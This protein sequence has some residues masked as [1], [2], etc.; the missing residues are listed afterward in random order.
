M[1]TIRYQS[2]N[3]DY[4]EDTLSFFL[5]NVAT[6]FDKYIGAVEFDGTCDR[7]FHFVFN[8]PTTFKKDRSKLLVY[9][10]MLMKPIVTKLKLSETMIAPDW[11]H[12]AF[13]LTN[14]YKDEDVYAQLG[15]PLKCDPIRKWFKGFDEDKCKELAQDYKNALALENKKP[16]STFKFTHLTIKNV[17][18]KMCDFIKKNRNSVKFDKFGSNLKYLMMRQHYIFIELSKEKMEHI[19]SHLKLWFEEEKFDDEIQMKEYNY[20]DEITEVG[21]DL[22]DTPRY[23]LVK[24]IEFLRHEVQSMR[25][26]DID[27]YIKKYRDEVE[28]R[29]KYYQQILVLEA[30][31]D[32]LI[33]QLEIIDQTPDYEK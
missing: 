16:T 15:Y 17:I 22:T 29:Q 24:E 5:S 33:E 13:Q 11:R 30:E 23:E 6:K 2:S 8:C 25:S 3:A 4:F 32:E 28:L 10:K 12:K 1:L 18:P 31:R 14:K 9:L 21:V 19:Y 20:N 26:N 27:D 7:H